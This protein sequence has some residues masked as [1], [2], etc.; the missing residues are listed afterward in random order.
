L[1]NLQQM[2]RGGARPNSGGAR[3]G[4]G[5]KLDPSALEWRDFWR[6]KFNDSETRR[7]L[8]TL[9]RGL[10]KTGDVALLCKLVDKTFPTPQELDLN[11]NR[12]PE[13]LIFRSV[14][15]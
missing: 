10:A 4:A 7:W 15:E 14:R 12:L 8:W 5:R 13:D 9:A 2:G 1:V 11:V 6:G 3:A